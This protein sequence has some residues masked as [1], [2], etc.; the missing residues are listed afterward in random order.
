MLTLGYL[1]QF[2]SACISWYGIPTIRALSQDSQYAFSIVVAMRNEE[3]GIAHFIQNLLDLD[4]PAQGFEI[5]L[6]DD[7]S[8]DNSLEIAREWE[9]KVPQLRVLSMA[10]NPIPITSSFKK[11]AI[12]F[13]VQEASF[14]WIVTTDVDCRLQSSHLKALAQS[15]EQY[16]PVFISGPVLYYGTGFFAKMQAVE[17]TGL[18]QLG[19]AYIAK[20]TPFL[21]NGAN[22]AFKREVYLRLN[23]ALSKGESGDDVWFLHKVARRY[24]FELCFAKHPSMRVYTNAMP[25]LKA[26]LHQRKRWTSKNASY[27][28]NNQRLVLAM[29][30]L[31]YVAILASFLWSIWDNTLLWVALAMLGMKALVEMLF[32]RLGAKF[33]KQPWWWWSYLLAIPF[34]LLYVVLIYPLSQFSQYSWKNRRFHA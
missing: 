5:V 10:Q 13:G 25:S 8:E 24:P 29:D 26:F 17:F 33:F 27:P 34:Q 32:F 16:Q 14:K 7:F 1:W 19:A 31:F 30:Y 4:Y 11:H 23:G 18:V 22:M 15:I 28:K 20:E 9:Q 2:V 3:Q 6:V 12:H 21:C